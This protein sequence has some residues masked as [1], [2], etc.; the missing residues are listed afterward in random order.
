MRLRKSL[1]AYAGVCRMEYIP[2]EAP[3]MFIPLFLGATSFHDMVGLH[4]I[5]ALLIFILLYWS[6]FLINALSDV[7]VDSKYKTFVSNSVHV[8]GEKTLKNLIVTHVVIAFLLL[9]HLCYLLN[10]Y[11]IFIFVLIATFFGLAYSVE[12]FHFKVRGI[13]HVTLAFGAI[14]APVFFLYYVV[15]GMPSV[16]II[17]IMLTLTMVHYG[18]ALVNQSQDYLEDRDAGLKTP[19]VRWGLTRTLRVAYILALS[20]LCLSFFGVYLIFSD[21]PQIVI[22][23]HSFSLWAVLF[24]SIMVLILGYFTPLKGLWDLIKISLTEDAIEQKMKRIK[25]RL[26]YPKWQISGIIGLVIVSTLYFSMKIM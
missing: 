10:N 12:P 22:L 9:V 1:R 18:I 24:I 6:G 17:L 25:T 8:L 20:S 14:F 11:W 3:G 21:L 5:E 19:A 4:V 15:G 2:G 26:D 23:G 7:E 16:P 13:F